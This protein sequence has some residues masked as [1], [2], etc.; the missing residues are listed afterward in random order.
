MALLSRGVKN[1]R[2][3]YHSMRRKKRKAPVR[4]FVL[5]KLPAKD[6]HIRLLPGQTMLAIPKNPTQ[7]TLS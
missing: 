6:E 1:V 3:F 4:R 5:Q 2:C 7:K